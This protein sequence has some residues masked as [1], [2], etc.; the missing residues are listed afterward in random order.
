MVCYT[1]ISNS[2]T[3]SQLYST[4][5]SFSWTVPGG[6]TSVAVTLKGASG[7][8]CSPAKSGY[9]SIVSATLKVTPGSSLIIY[10]G[11]EGTSTGGGFNGGGDG[12]GASVIVGG[13]GATDIRTVDSLSNRVVVAGGGGGGSAYCYSNGGNGGYP[14]GGSGWGFGGPCNKSCTILQGDRKLLVVWVGN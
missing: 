11:G 10:V 1:K 14:S 3:V 5:G 6:V 4:P 12:M 8:S 2:T 9:G 7:G 13:G